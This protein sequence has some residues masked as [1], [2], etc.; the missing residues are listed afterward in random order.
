M[1]VR[2]MEFREATLRR[3]MVFDVPGN[4]DVQAYV[5]KLEA[6]NRMK[7]LVQGMTFDND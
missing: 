5:D 1:L 2:G 3:C 7:I 4:W 6:A